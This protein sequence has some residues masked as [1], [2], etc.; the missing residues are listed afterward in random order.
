MTTP[1]EL[2]A[3]VRSMIPVLDAMGVEVVEA[4]RN[5]VAAR[6]PAGPN[7][8]HFGTAYAGSLFTVAEVLGG[9]YASTSLVLEGAVPLVKSLT[10]DF[11]RPATTDVVARATLDD[12]VI[13]RVLA[14]TT[15]HGKSDFELVAE[16]TDADGTVVA[17]TRGLYQMRRF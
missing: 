9:L 11:L 12:D 2:T 17:R 4:G 8:N 16:V 3:H 10:I 15:E 6:L 13:N 1:A 14:E 7:V 5:T